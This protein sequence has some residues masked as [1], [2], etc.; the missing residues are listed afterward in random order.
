MWIYDETNIFARILRK[1]VPCTP[2]FEDSHALCF[3]DLYP[4]APFHA[5]L[6]P[7]GPYVNAQHFY[8]VASTEE[9][10]SLQKA[11]GV[12]AERYE[13]DKEGGFRLLSNQGPNARQEVPHFHIHILAKKDLGPTLA[14]GIV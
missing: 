6:I 12:I 9:I 4:Q 1:E 14:S 10:M 5:L 11:I 7:K 8:S 2:L 13:L 3:S